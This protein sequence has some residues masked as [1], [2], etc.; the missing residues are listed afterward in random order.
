MV[1]GHP[2]KRGGIDNG[3][4]ELERFDVGQA[5]DAVGRARSRV[6]IVNVKLPEL[7]IV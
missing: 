1:G 4:G 6:A 5:V 7:L 3:V 2:G